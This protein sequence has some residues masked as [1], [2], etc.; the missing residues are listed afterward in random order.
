M[1]NSERLIE[2]IQAF[3]KYHILKEE[4]IQTNNQT[5]LSRLNAIVDLIDAKSLEA[6]ADLMINEAK[7]QL[8]QL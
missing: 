1:C 6:G 8:N 5:N 7:K 4:A 2:G 3:E